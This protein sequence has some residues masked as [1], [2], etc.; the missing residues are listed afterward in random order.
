MEKNGDLS[1]WLLKGKSFK[2]VFFSA[3][4]VILLDRRYRA[5]PELM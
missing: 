5:L 1:D 3:Y 2:R 4:A